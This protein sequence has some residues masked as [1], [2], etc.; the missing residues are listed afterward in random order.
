MADASFAIQAQTALAAAK[1]APTPGRAADVERIR[2][3]AVEFEAFYLGQVLQPMF[4]ELGADE[5]FSGGVA[6][7]MWRSL[8]VEE[9]GKAIARAGGVGLADVVFREML[10]MQ[11]VQ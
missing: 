3:T 7:D 10:R 1:K 6:E 4:A 8:R 9:Y 5:P 11:E 2:R